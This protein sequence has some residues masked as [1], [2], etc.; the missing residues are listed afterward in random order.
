MINTRLRAADAHDALPICR[1]REQVWLATYPNAAY[2]VT[3]D[4]LRAVY[5][6]C[7]PER[8]QTFRTLIKQKP[9]IV[10]EPLTDAA[11][12]RSLKYRLGKQR[13]EPVAYAA[14][15]RPSNE[16]TMLYVLPQWQRQGIGDACMRWSID[17]LDSTRP[18]VVHVVEYNTA[19]LA[20]YGRHGFTIVGESPL[21]HGAVAT[22]LNMPMLEL[23]R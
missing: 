8:V 23:R 18:V 3:A 15:D 21:N 17:N 2:G 12:R 13:P 7:A 11:S 9:V 5:R 6:F 4:E 16:L 20:F 19:A 10:I 1:L 22:P 14:V